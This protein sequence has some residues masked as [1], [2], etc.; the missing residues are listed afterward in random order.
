MSDEIPEDHEIPWAMQLVVHRDRAHPAREVDVAEAAA[1]AV[2]T[3]LALV[4]IVPVYWMVNSAFQSDSA[5]QSTDV[6]LVPTH[7]TVEN[8]TAVLTDSS[9]WSAMGVSLSAALICVVVTTAAALLAAFAASRY[10][11]VGR[12]GLIVAILVI[13]VKLP[14]HALRSPRRVRRPPP[15]P[16]S[17]RHRRVLI[18]VVRRPRRSRLQLIEPASF[19]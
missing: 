12:R 7:P 15:P 10:T 6:A 19:V 9:F 5:L 2:V 1:R 16:T 17:R 8:F 14:Y 11:F 18:W 3:L 13:L 4:W